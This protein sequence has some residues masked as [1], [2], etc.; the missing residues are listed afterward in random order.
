LDLVAAQIAELTI[1]APVDGVV[2]TSSIEV[3]EVLQAGA[4]AMTIGS[5]TS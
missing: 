2:L 3:G 1:H 4:S 5:S